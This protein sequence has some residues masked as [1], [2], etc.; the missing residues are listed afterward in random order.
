M[1]MLIGQDISKWNNIVDVNAG[2]F[3]IIKAT[4]GETY[5]DP[6]FKVYVEQLN[7]TQLV[8]FYHFI[9]ADIEGNDAWREAHKF[10]DTIINAGFMYK[11]LLVVDYERKSVGHEDYLLRFLDGVY[12]M[13]GIKPIVYCSCSVAKKLNAVREKGYEF[14][15]AHYNTKHIKD[16]LGKSNLMWQFTSSPWDF[17]IFYG[18]RADWIKRTKKSS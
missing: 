16:S 10:V 17:D 14:W 3:T 13:T 11:S 2:D 1:K 8:G 15:I 7:S 4:E 6:K 9:R 18:D 12:I 5:T